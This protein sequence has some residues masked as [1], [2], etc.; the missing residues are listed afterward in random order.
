M[1]IVLAICA[2]IGLSAAC[3]FRVFLPLLAASLAAHFGYL[4]P[5][6]GMFWIGSTPA[7]VLFS[8]ATV[9]EIA[10][11]YIPWVDHALDVIATPTAVLAGAVVA[12]TAL[13]DIHPAVKWTAA[14]IAGGGVAGTI[15]GT[16]VLARGA[17]TA[18]TGGVGNPII[19]TLEAIAATVL[20]ILAVVVP[21]VAALLV[22]V[23]FALVIRW[24][25]R[26]RS[27]AVSATPAPTTM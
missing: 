2:G 7:M 25:A 21:I 24:W 18:T 19:A 15:Q 10:G 9:V 26:R 4:H 11:Y 12:A 14:L 27:A 17:S 20:A 23:T 5:S 1:Q 22:V 3:G 6:P 8:V 13:G 16:T